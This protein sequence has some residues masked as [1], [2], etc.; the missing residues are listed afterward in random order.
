MLS[1]D[2]LL[3]LTYHASKEQLPRKKNP[4][5]QLEGGN[6]Q[7]Y[8]MQVPPPQESKKITNQGSLADAAKKCSRA[9]E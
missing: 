6:K 4:W 2:S 3:L 9:L 5:H 8:K 7:L 1:E